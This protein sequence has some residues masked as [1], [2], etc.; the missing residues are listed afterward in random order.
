[1]FDYDTLRL[2]TWVVI[3][4]LLIGFAIA[5][6]FDIGVAALLPMLGKNNLERR[7]MIN[8]IAPHWDGNQVWLITA[9]G[10]IFAVWPLVYGAAFSSFYLA[11]IFVLA[12]L[13]L[14]PIGM[15]Y[16][17]K[18]DSPKWRTACDMALFVSGVIPPIIFGVGFGNLLV[19][20]PFELNPLLMLDYQGGLFDL[21]TPLPILC[22]LV[23]LSMTVTQGATFLQM[24][25][26]DVLRMRAQKVASYSAV[27]TILLFV[28]GG[29]MASSQ[30]G[31]TIIGTLVKDAASNPLNKQVVSDA[32]E[33]L[34]NFRDFPLL[35]LIPISAIVSLILS[36]LA[37]AYQRAGL[38][39]SLSSVAI[40]SIIITAGA[41]LFPMIMPSSMNPSHSLTLWDATSSQ[42]TLS[43]I[44]VVAIVVVPVILSY[45]A[46]CYYKM[47]GRLDN[48]Y[49]QNNS[50]SLY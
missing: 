18:I 1:M 24:K 37:S 9:G 46:W 7:V 35:W 32:G 4:V 43:I 41:A 20:V 25:T 40:A 42:K 39:F 16:R 36:V 11:M 13:W 31:Y 48:D 28:L 26:K 47:F 3:G 5:D 29:F 14:R 10:A 19:G 22:G 8:T 23:S 17:A 45:T 12:T 50:S 27:T 6:G 21:L 2:F 33:L 49:V 34:H 44:S 15:D 30:P 38:A